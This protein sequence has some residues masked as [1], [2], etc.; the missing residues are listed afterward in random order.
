[1]VFRSRSSRKSPKGYFVC[2]RYFYF[3]LCHWLTLLYPQFFH[4]HT[5][6]RVLQFFNGHLQ[7]ARPFFWG[8]AG[9][10]WESLREC[11]TDRRFVC[12]N[13]NDRSKSS[14]CRDAK[15]VESGEFIAKD[16]PMKDFFWGWRFFFPK[17]WKVGLKNGSETR[18]CS[19]LLDVSPDSHYSADISKMLRL[20]EPFQPPKDETLWHG[21]LAKATPSKLF[22]MLV[23]YSKAHRTLKKLKANIW[24]Q[25]GQVAQSNKY[26]WCTN[27]FSSCV[28]KIYI[29]FSLCM[30]LW[31]CQGRTCSRYQWW[32]HVRYHRG[33]TIQFE[34]QWS[35]ENHGWMAWREMRVRKQDFNSAIK[36]LELTLW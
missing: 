24:N 9:R 13:S 17:N 30:A 20:Q 1:M 5:S 11:K 33:G 23:D 18:V 21:D 19:K 14:R 31:G 7:P 36:T 35:G 15:L 28:H 26:L 4:L 25:K 3:A 16:L 2:L 34:G 27:K 10:L 12:K 29:I 22:M 32:C 8:N 6:Q